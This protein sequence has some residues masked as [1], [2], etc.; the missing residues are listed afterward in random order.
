VSSFSGGWR[1]RLNLARAL[2]ETPPASRDVAQ[3][4]AQLEQAE[5]LLRTAIGLAPR[6]VEPHALLGQLLAMLGRGAEARS[7]LERAIVLEPDDEQ[8]KILR[9]LLE[10][11]R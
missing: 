2:I 1:V 10:G 8:R 9:G 4:V 3:R 7:E 11:V 6:S 5:A